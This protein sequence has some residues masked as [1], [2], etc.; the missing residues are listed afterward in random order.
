MD[1]SE[2]SDSGESSGSSPKSK[3]TKL[4]LTDKDFFASIIENEDKIVCKGQ[5]FGT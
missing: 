4:S 1:S 3:R 5:S 2:S